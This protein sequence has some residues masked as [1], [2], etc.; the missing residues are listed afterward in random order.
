MDTASYSHETVKKKK[1]NICYHWSSER[2]EKKS[3][4]EK[5]LEEIVTANFPNFTY[6]VKKLIEAQI[7]KTQ[8]NSSQDTRWSK[9]RKPTIEILEE[10]KWKYLCKA[11]LE[12]SL[13]FY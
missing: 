7:G 5:V 12:N 10:G 9:F 2:K 3:T 1:S 8:R 4:T 13:K 11:T 6:I